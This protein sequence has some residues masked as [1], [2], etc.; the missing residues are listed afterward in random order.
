[1][2]K[3]KWIPIIV[4]IFTIIGFGIC[5]FACSLCFFGKMEYVDLLSIIS[6]V[7]SISLALISTH[8]SFSSGEKTS[9]QMEETSKYLE[10]LK[11]HTDEVK[12]HMEVVKK[13]YKSFVKRIN[14]ENARLNRN[15]DNIADARR[16][17][18]IIKPDNNQQNK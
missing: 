5:L 17:G 8:Y 11:K 6:S 16:A 2:T 18:K 4:L 3:G 13:D 10:E 12:S 1:M 7:I 15:R 9:K 14:L